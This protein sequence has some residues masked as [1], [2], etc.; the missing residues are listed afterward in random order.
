MFESVQSGVLMDRPFG[1]VVSL[2]NKKLRHV[3]E[4]VC[5]RERYTVI[6]VINYLIVNVYL[7]CVGTADRLLICSNIFADI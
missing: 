5:Y 4:T 1:G 2:V 7:P 3:T 6:K